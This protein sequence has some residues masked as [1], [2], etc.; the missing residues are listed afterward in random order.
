MMELSNMTGVLFYALGAVAVAGALGVV[1]MKNPV[2]CALSLA[3]SFL[4]LAG[5]YLLSGAE[6][7]A[8]IQVIVYAG[9]VM[10]LF[11]FVIMLLNLGR[12]LRAAV[13]SPFLVAGGIGLGVVFLLEGFALLA[14]GA[15]SGSGHAPPQ[16]GSTELMGK[17][18]FSD[19]ILAFEAASVLL[20]VGIVGAVA[21]LRHE[22]EG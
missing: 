11:L 13:R 19:Y 20:L 18:L 9:A 21:L 16:I 2:K 15:P 10:V 3:L 6:F 22:G 14:R 12:E 5:I 1:I 4:A 8:A 7:I 17:L